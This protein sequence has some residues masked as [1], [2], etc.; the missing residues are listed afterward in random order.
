MLQ[1]DSGHEA[2]KKEGCCFLCCCYKR[3]LNT[4]QE[5]DTCFYWALDNNKVR[6]DSYVQI[7]KDTFAKEIAEKYGRSVRPVKF[8]KGKNH[9]YLVDEQGNEVYNSVKPGYGH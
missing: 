9:F 2:V 7:N 5:A 1:K 6:G 3:G 8:V 4:I